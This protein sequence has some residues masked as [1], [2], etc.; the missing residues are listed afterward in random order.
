M[1]CWAERV[2]W[3]H[4]QMFS[5]CNLYGYH[6]WV[7]LSMQTWIYR[8]L[9]KSPQVDSELSRRGSLLFYNFF[10]FEI[11]V[12]DSYKCCYSQ[13]LIIN[14][15]IF[16]P[17]NKQDGHSNL[18][19][20]ENRRFVKSY[21]QINWWPIHFFFRVAFLFIFTKAFISHYFRIIKH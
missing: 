2:R 20:A 11:G 4:T 18:R 1:R 9:T 6:R 14:G 3:W 17:I 19:Y 10:W 8:F 7:H 13:V 21:N 16:G 15:I 5:S 12:A